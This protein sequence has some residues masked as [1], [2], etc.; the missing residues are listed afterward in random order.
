MGVASACKTNQAKLAAYGYPA[1]TIFC[2]IV[3]GNHYFADAA[4]GLAALAISYLIVSRMAQP[5]RHCNLAFHPIGRCARRSGSSVLVGGPE[6]LNDSVPTTR[7]L[8]QATDAAS[9]S[10][11]QEIP[12]TAA[13]HRHS[14]PQRWELGRYSP[15]AARSPRIWLRRPR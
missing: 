15:A 5:R 13:P 4:A 7:T 2:I 11:G 14:H 10:A 9:I 6:P 12:R 3:T 8:A 1:L